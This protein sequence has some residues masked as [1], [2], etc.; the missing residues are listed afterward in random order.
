MIDEQ[1]GTE[2]PCAVC[3]K[4]VDNCI[5][6]ECRQ[7]DSQGDPRCYAVEASC[8]LK[9]SREQVLSRMDAR[10]SHLREDLLGEEMIREMIAE[11]GDFSPL[12]SDN[13]DPW[14]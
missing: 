12:L 7:C 2:Q 10:I 3:A 9:L 5:C 6:P 8:Q 11:G 13:P 1:M 4:D 14:R